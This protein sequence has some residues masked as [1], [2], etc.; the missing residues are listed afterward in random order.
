MGSGW[1]G[2]VVVFLG[3]VAVCC[4]LLLLL[5]VFLLLL[6][7]LLLLCDWDSFFCGFLFKESCALFCMS[8]IEKYLSGK[9]TSFYVVRTLYSL[10]RGGGRGR[11]RWVCV[12]VGKKKSL[13]RCAFRGFGDRVREGCG[14]SGYRR[15]PEGKKVRARRGIHEA[16]PAAPATFTRGTNTRQWEWGGG[17]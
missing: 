7:L 10:K 2:G 4:C 6:L 13:T 3:F 17:W 9:T 8:F 1:G 11:G 12:G 16:G 5:L 14:A 15:G